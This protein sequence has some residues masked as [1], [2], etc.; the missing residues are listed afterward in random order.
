MTMT[1]TEFTN[2][3]ARRALFTA[4]V[5]GMLLSARP[6]SAAAED[7][8]EKPISTGQYIA[9]GIVG[10]LAG[11]GIGHG[12]VG[13]YGRIGW[14]F[15]VTEGVATIGFGVGYAMAVGDAVN[16]ANGVNGDSN[17]SHD[18]VRTRGLAIALISLAVMEGMHIWEI[19]DIWTAPRDRIVHRSAAV[20]EAPHFMVLPVVTD[21][22]RGLAAVLT[23]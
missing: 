19:V 17:S 1:S 21:T 3:V 8:S 13:D 4:L 7:G 18:A 10:T 20:A 16:T 23:F 9:G 2:P 5:A 14:L 11:Y 6:A 15:S 12:I 22:T